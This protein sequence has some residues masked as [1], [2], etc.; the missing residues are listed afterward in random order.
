MNPRFRA[1]KQISWG[2]NF[3]PAAAFLKKGKKTE[4]WATPMQS[5]GGLARA[6]SVFVFVSASYTSLNS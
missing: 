3:K 5:A 4:K 1:S 2:K 6:G